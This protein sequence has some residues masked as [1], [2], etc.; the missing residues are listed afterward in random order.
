M[1]GRIPCTPLQH[2]AEPPPAI[3]SHNY[4][5]TSSAHTTFHIGVDFDPALRETS[6]FV[7]WTN[8]IFVWFG[9]LFLASYLFAKNSWRPHEF[10]VPYNIYELLPNIVIVAVVYGL[11]QSG[12]SRYRRLIFE[13]VKHIGFGFITFGILVEGRH[14][15]AALRLNNVFDVEAT[16]EV[17]YSLGLAAV[18]IATCFAVA[19]HSQTR[20]KPC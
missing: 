17:A 14:F 5:E 12:S 7:K 11:L 2:V 9:L 16:Y 19:S 20:V 3:R 8:N 15:S 1:S 13:A 6:A 4:C 10:L 18:V